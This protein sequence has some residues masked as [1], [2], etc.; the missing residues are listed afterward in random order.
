MDILRQI[1]PDIYP[2]RAL[3]RRNLVIS[4]MK[5]YD[6]VTPSE[7]DSNIQGMAIFICRFPFHMS[8]YCG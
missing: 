3:Q 2:D 6:V 8:Y 5:K 1:N 7:A 4:Q